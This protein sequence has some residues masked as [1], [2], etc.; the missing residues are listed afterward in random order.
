M[1]PARI[2][3]HFTEWDINPMYGWDTLEL[4]LDDLDEIRDDDH[5]R[6]ILADAAITLINMAVDEIDR[7]WSSYFTWAIHI[8]DTKMPMTYREQTLCLGEAAR[9]YRTYNRPDYL[10]VIQ[11]LIQ[12]RPLKAK[13]T[14]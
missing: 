11:E 8:I 7:G 5:L 14:T 2:N 4:M 10:S 9:W 13:E 1:M 6:E 12:G 3:R